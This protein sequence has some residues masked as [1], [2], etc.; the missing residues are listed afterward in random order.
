MEKKDTMKKRSTKDGRPRRAPRIP[1][2][3]IEVPDVIDYKDVALLKKFLTDRGKVMP[4]RFTGVSAKEQ[5]LVV[6]A[7]KRARFLG[8]LSSGSAKRK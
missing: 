2:I 5:R 1:R 8:L 7:I 4:R 3:Q 6:V